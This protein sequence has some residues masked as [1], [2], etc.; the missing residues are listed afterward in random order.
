MDED[1]FQ[2]KNVVDKN[3]VFYRAKAWLQ[4][5]NPNFYKYLKDM[6]GF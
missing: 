2:F 1:D 6:I 3:T 4:T 5:K